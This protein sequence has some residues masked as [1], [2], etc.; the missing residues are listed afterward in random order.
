MYTKNLQGSIQGIEDTKQFE[1]AVWSVIKVDAMFETV[2][3]LEN[4]SFFQQRYNNS[5]KT[6]V[7]MES[8]I[9]GF[10]YI[11]N[12]LVEND[13][14][15]M[16]TGGRE[17]SLL[18]N[19]IM[20]RMSKFNA[21]LIYPGNEM[22]KQDCITEITMNMSKKGENV[23]IHDDGLK[24]VPIIVGL[25]NRLARQSSS[26]LTILADIAKHS[27]FYSNKDG[28]RRIK[29]Q[30]FSLICQYDTTKN[31]KT[32]HSFG[33]LQ[34]FNLM[35]FKDNSPLSVLQT[36]SWLSN[37]FSTE[38]ITRTHALFLSFEKKRLQ[39]GE[40]SPISILQLSGIDSFSTCLEICEKKYGAKI[41]D[42]K[43]RYWMTS[44]DEHFLLPLWTTSAKK[45]VGDVFSEARIDI[46]TFPKKEFSHMDLESQSPAFAKTVHELS[47][48]LKDGFN[49]LIL[50]IGSRGVGKSSAI[51]EACKNQSI[52][53]N[54]KLVD[55]VDFKWSNY[56]KMVG[57]E[58][59]KAPFTMAFTF[60]APHL[61]GFSETDGS[62]ENYSVT[63]KECLKQT[64][65]AVFFVRLS[66]NDFPPSFMKMFLSYLRG[67]SCIVGVPDWS[68][69]DLRYCH[70]SSTMEIKIDPLL[71]IHMAVEKYCNTINC[72]FF[73]SPSML[74]MAYQ[75]TDLRIKQNT[76]ILQTRRV[77]LD[78]VLDKLKKW[79]EMIDSWTIE[80]E[81]VMR[82]FQL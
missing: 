27:F 4:E 46:T 73:P 35:S 79:D 44:L 41:E 5:D 11:L 3:P 31:L 58:S 40:N 68:A 55:P 61:D 56:E 54:P 17:G 2:N 42:E 16:I 6:W 82:I 30:N 47:N 36:H 67:H 14:P 48:T 13:K 7:R 70:D 39:L 22:N 57:K 8:P 52:T 24:T 49:R 53:L 66:V 38:M 23:F 51:A 76:E 74:K 43:E 18:C 81:K 50:V 63:L 28:Y 64:K 45:V 80:L 65:K 77:L 33:G 62:L 9:E 19:A 10:M 20:T 1:G 21:H 71:N 72:Q 60:T 59:K 26:L 15:V 37:M 75:S 25:E 34:Y 78:G 32:F 12:L 29:L 69:N